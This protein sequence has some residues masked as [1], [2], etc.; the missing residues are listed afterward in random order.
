MNIHSILLASVSF[1]VL[2]GVAIAADLPSK[3]KPAAFSTPAPA[4]T[5]A[6]AYVGVHGGFASF[7]PNYTDTQDAPTNPSVNGGVFGAVAGYNVQ[8]GALVYGVDGDFGFG[9]NRKLSNTAVNTFSKFTMPLNGH[10]RGRLGYAL[11]Q[12]LFFVAGGAAFAAFKVD[13]IDPGYGKFT[14][15][16]VG[17]TVGAGVEQALTNNWIVRGEYLYDRFGGQ[18]SNISHT[19][20]S[21]A[22]DAH[23][24]PGMHTVRAALVYKF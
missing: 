11:G 8:S 17:W 9:T 6:G 14:Q 12:T 4:F 18:T 23:I 15:S 5:W 7:K 2:S 13:D 1:I 16:R 3:T 24:K 19:S 10:L 21:S 22:Y 20:P